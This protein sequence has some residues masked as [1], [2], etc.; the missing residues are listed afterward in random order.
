MKS[1]DLLTTRQPDPDA[2][3]EENPVYLSDRHVH[4]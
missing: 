1:P 3:A 2:L 4:K